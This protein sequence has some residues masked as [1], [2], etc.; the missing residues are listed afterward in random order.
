MACLKPLW[1]ALIVL[2][3]LVC[4]DAHA[5]EAPPKRGALPDQAASPEPAP[6][7]KKPPPR[8]RAARQAVLT[9][10]PAPAPPAAYHPSLQPP[11]PPPLPVPALPQPLN[12]CDGGGCNA[13]DGTRLNGGVGNT[14]LDDKGR[15]CTR[16]GNNVQCF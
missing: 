3:S 4:N 6:L 13:V 14:L 11:A 16:S 15:L 2:S 9:M 1:V 5:Q 12:H 10:P 7:P 8:R